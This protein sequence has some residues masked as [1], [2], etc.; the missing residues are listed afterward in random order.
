[1]LDYRVHLVDPNLG[2]HETLA[3]TLAERGFGHLVG[4]RVF[5]H[6]RT[7]EDALPSLLKDV[8][9]HGS[10]IFALDQFGYTAVPF[11][12]LRQIFA[13][14]SKPEVI[15]TFVYDQLVDLDLA[16]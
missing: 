4:E 16:V 8:K 9:G 15:L 11:D 7:F 3:R 14:L 13:T 1:M 2:A 10:T 6:Q 5:L 12:L